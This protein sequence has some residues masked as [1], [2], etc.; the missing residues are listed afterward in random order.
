MACEGSPITGAQ[1]LQ[2]I[3]ARCDQL[4]AAGL[5]EQDRC[6]I[7]AGRGN[8]YWLD[9]LAVW[10]L[11]GVVIPVQEH[12]TEDSLTDIVERTCPKFALGVQN[13][14]GSPTLADVVQIETPPDGQ[15]V[16]LP[17]IRDDG[18]L[19]AY[20]TFTSGSTS[21]PKIVPLTHDNLRLNAMGT[22]PRLPYREDERLFAPIPFRFISSISHC[23][24]TILARG[25]FMGYEN[26]G[27]K[28]MML[29]TLKKT[30]ATA[31]GGS[32]LQVR[33][34]AE[35]L[36]EDRNAFSLNWA[37]SSGDNL[38][39]SVTNKL[40]ELSPSTKVM[41][42]Y[43]L[44][45]LGGRFCILDPEL[46]ASKPDSV[47]LPIESLSVTIVNDDGEPCA[48]GELG[49]VVASGGALFQGYAGQ[50]DINEQSFGPHGF[51]TGDVGLVDENGLLYLRGRSDDVFKSA[52]Q[53]VSCLLIAQ[54]LIKSD[55]FEDVAVVS[56]EDDL[57]GLA[58]HVYYVLKQ[59]SSGPAFKKGAV[60]RMLKLV[61][62][63]NHIPS[64]F[65]EVE[66]IPR[67]A[68]GKLD[69]RGMRHLQEA[70][71]APS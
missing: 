20:L 21:R 28:G 36:E 64:H 66:R 8:E 31:F 19:L 68:S 58:P 65:I 1:A 14:S 63:T 37:M 69:R 41:I 10:A 2:Y 47:G 6:L 35:Q 55:L 52:G 25:V 54:E 40:L 70:R 43:G 5:S 71:D 16:G 30:E 57:L 34:I 4:A 11:N 15:Q 50:D 26:C 24:V 49:R 48:T 44:T 7:F 12:E 17:E 61:L 60:L 33:W 38:P 53:K 59:V 3:G 46:S 45:E 27:V 18:S 62:P 51:D 22:L 32:P 29:Q 13:H 67:T 9:S 23:L 56:G 39:T 42:V